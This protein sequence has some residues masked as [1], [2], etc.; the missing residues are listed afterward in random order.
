MALSEDERRDLLRGNG[1]LKPRCGERGAVLEDC[2]YGPM[3]IVR[4]S[5]VYDFGVMG[6]IEGRGDEIWSSCCFDGG[7]R[8]R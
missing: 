4:V 1:Q 2:E 5:C 3:S 6:L 8:R 7:L